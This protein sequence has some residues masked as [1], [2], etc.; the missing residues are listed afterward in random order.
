MRADP[1][2]EAKKMRRTLRKGDSTSSRRR[3]LTVYPP[4]VSSRASFGSLLDFRMGVDLDICRGWCGVVAVRDGCVKPC[5]MWLLSSNSRGVIMCVCFIVC[6][7]V[8][9]RC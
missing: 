8:V 6:R 2:E 9:F 4:K 3:C 7:F 1:A 5:V